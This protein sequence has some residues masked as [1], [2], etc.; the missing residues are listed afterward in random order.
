M[1][2][3]VRV[4]IETG[5]KRVFASAADWPG[6]SRGGK[7]EASAL[8]A[9]STYAPRYAPVAKLAGLTFQVSGPGFE[10]VERMSG[11]GSTDFGVPGTPALDEARPATAAQVKRLRSLL[12][13]SWTYLDAARRKAPPAL[14][15]GPR[16]G[17]R[18]REPIYA[19]VLGAEVEYAKRIG[20]RL[21]Q[22]RG[23]DAAAVKSFRNSILE[24]LDTSNRETKWPLA[25]FVRRA[26][27]HALDHAWEIEDRIP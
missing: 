20:L 26:A 19:H 12:E 14:R 8:E 3:K 5:S 27:W 25:Y 13:A 10:V 2:G 18:D 15:K 1:P 11:G 22:P 24:G 7:D 21:E 9:L 23:E 6:W 16:G 4:Y 17:G